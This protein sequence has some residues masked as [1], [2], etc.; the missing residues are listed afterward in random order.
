MMGF[1][2][3]IAL[4][5]IFR[6]STST[7][8]IGAEMADEALV[9]TSPA[10]V[11]GATGSKKYLGP[12]GSPR[13]EHLFDPERVLMGGARV[14]QV[15]YLSLIRHPFLVRYPTVS[16]GVNLMRQLCT[17]QAVGVASSG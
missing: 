5:A 9:R 6:P 17:G 1:P 10:E 2:L 3:P 16:I 8:L 12:I 7:N 14:H 13:S 11:S 15:E 4:Y